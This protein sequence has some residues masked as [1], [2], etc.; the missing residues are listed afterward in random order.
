MGCIAARNESNLK[1]N[2]SELF[3]VQ[4]TK[5]TQPSQEMF[6]NYGDRA[7][8][9]ALD[10]HCI[11]KGHHG[12]TLAVADGAKKWLGIREYP[13]PRY[14]EQLGFHP[15]TPLNGGQIAA[16]SVMETIQ[17][18]PSL[19]G[20]ALV[21]QLNHDLA[22]H[23]HE[24]GV[25]PSLENR[26]EVFTTSFV[27]ARITDRHIT[28]TSVGDC[29]MAINGRLVAQTHKRIDDIVG[30]LL[31]S[32]AHDLQEPRQSLY[33]R[34]MPVLRPLMYERQ[35][36]LGKAHWYPVID[37]TTTPPAGIITQTID[38]SVVHSLI[39]WTDGLEPITDTIHSLNDLRPSNPLYGEQTA[40]AI[41][42]LAEPEV[43]V[44]ATKPFVGMAE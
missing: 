22:H 38:R 6:E 31:G 5:F 34:L 14:A 43:V 18:Q 7:H 20:H 32:L 39:L 37:G 1:I 9:W 26:L 42:Q 35:N 40:I 41:S 10:Q 11:V 23:Y 25:E 27:H 28:V 30:D 15:H 17:H 3:I 21:R 16:L 44:K 4:I 19:A 36:R 12:L 24:L 8:S 13:V 33:L 29:S 2:V